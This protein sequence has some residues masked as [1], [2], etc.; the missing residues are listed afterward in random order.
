MN[1]LKKL[2]SFRSL[3]AKF[4][5]ITVPLVLVSTIALFAAILINTQRAAIIDLQT[6]LETLA[7]INSTLL[8]GPLSKVNRKQISLILAA[9]LNDPEMVGAVVYDDTGNVVSNAGRMT[10]VSGNVLVSDAATELGGENIGRLEVAV[11]DHR[12]QERTLQHIRIAAGMAFLL[13]L[14]VVLSVLVAHSRTVGTP[15]RLLSESIRMARERGV[16]QSVE[17]QSND[18]MG[19]VVTAYNDMQRRQHSDEQALIVARDNLEQR[20]EERTRELATAQEKAT[21]SR[22]EAMR[23]PVQLNPGLLEDR[24]R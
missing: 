2:L 21:L 22:D 1:S 23:A 13:V 20:V 14:S 4:L 19:A 5:A 17:W 12:L 16:R 9:M 8:A 6:R 15:L 7:V 18:E 3:E 24:S 11:S 10:A